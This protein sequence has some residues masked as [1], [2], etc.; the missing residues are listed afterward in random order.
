LLR[1]TGLT[2]APFPLRPR[3]F[4]FAKNA[5]VTSGHWR[6]AAMAAG[7]RL[8]LGGGVALRLRFAK[9]FSP[10]SAPLSP[11][12]DRRPKRFVIKPPVSEM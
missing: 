7:F 9:R 8:R 12:A 3:L 2:V 10:P 1:F 11:L 6:I 4:R 5:L